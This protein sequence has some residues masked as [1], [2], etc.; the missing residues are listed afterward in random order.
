M[1]RR[2]ESD[3]RTSDQKILTKW[4]FLLTKQHNQTTILVS[5][6]FLGSTSWGGMWLISSWT[7]LWQQ[8]C[9][10]HKQLRWNKCDKKSSE[11]PIFFFRWSDKFPFGQ[12][13]IIIVLA[14]GWAFD[15]CISQSKWE[16][17]KESNS[18]KKK[19]LVFAFSVVSL[20]LITNIPS[21]NSKQQ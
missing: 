19:G 4:I 21:S 13:E 2:R 5:L 8:S 18:Q 3:T 12:T 11:W 16:Q 17:E 14:T 15:V 20:C 1:T 9:S 10:K 7:H 6:V